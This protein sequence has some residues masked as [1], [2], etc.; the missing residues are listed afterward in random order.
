MSSKGGNK[1]P[2]Y[3]SKGSGRSSMKTAS[4]DPAVRLMN[5]QRA[6]LAGKTVNIS[7]P[8]YQERI[9]GKALLNKRSVGAD[10]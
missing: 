9:D 10:G 2:Q 7:V 1:K 8:G 3:I 4:K 6:M 5:Q